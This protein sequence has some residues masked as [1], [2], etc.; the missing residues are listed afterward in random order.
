MHILVQSIKN[1]DIL[2][3]HDMN[4]LKLGLTPL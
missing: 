3:F 4:L 1:R 2:T